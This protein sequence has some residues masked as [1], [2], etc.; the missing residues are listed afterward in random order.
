[1]QARN[2]GAGRGG[3][4]RGGVRVPWYKRFPMTSGIASLSPSLSLSVSVSIFL[5][6][7]HREVHPEKICTI[8][9]IQLIANKLK[10]YVPFLVAYWF[11][12][13][14]GAYIAY[15]SIA[16]SLRNDKLVVFVG[17]TQLH[18]EA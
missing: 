5:Y 10:V 6:L 7:L 4:E 12:C 8:Y 14:P 1:M 18:H 2:G 11:V 17:E 9:D 13:R 15:V 16:V 3:A